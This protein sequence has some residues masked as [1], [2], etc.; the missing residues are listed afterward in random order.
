MRRLSPEI[1]CPPSISVIVVAAV[2]STILAVAFV[3]GAL[4]C[5][6]FRWWDHRDV[7]RTRAT[8]AAPQVERACRAD[9]ASSLIVDAVQTTWPP[10][11]TARLRVRADGS[12]TCLC[13]DQPGTLIEIDLDGDGA[14]DV[15]ECG[16]TPFS[17]SALRA[18]VEFWRRSPK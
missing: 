13:D 5:E 6:L 10:R 14:T 8:P 11:D 16:C 2:A 15:L 1:V 12:L 18:S 4:A 3:L 17:E 9:E 7:A